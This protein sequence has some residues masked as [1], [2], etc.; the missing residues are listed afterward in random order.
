MFHYIMICRS[1]KEAKNTEE[2]TNR[3]NKVLVFCR[4]CRKKYIENKPEKKC[5]SCH[6]LFLKEEFINKE[7]GKNYLSCKQCRKDFQ[8]NNLAESNSL[9]KT[10][11]L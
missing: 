6:D 11:H 2:F 9:K 10:I 8:F 1:C 3:D 5:F 4:D 7:T